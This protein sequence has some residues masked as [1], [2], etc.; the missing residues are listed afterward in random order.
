MKEKPYFN[1]S[2]AHKAATDYDRKIQR[3][4]VL[5]GLREGT[6]TEAGG[7]PPRDRLRQRRTDEAGVYLVQDHR[8][9]SVRE[10]ATRQGS[11]LPDVTDR[12]G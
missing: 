11:K 8:Q 9:A 10:E 7:Y 3:S 5:D 12:E 4:V 2:H 1:K 6:S